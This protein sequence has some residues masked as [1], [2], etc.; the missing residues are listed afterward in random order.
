VVQ[1]YHHRNSSNCLVSHH[2]ITR[3]HII[4]FINILDIGIGTVC[5]VTGVDVTPAMIEKAKAR[6]Y[7]SLS[8]QVAHY[9]HYSL[10][11]VDVQQ[12]MI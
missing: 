10:I 6:P 1:D 9:R 5:N 7:S 4:T 3:I 12:I 8:V 11:G 2:I